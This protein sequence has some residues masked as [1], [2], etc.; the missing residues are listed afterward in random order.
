MDENYINSPLNWIWS[1]SDTNAVA[2]EAVRLLG[3][4][5]ARLELAGAQKDFVYQNLRSDI[6]AKKY[7]ILYESILKK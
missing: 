6:M 1:S 4:T 5:R 3:D 7:S 2:E